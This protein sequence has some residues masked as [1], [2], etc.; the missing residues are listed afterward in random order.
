MDD[1]S[2]FFPCCISL[3]DPDSSTDLDYVL[4]TGL[5]SG[6]A[7]PDKFVVEFGSEKPT[8]LIK[9]GQRISVDQT[10][11]YMRGIPVN[12]KISGIITE[13]TD[14][15]FI[16]IYDKATDNLMSDLGLKDFSDK[17]LQTL[18]TDKKE[19]KFDQLNDLLKESSF[20][21]N[22]IKDYILRFRCADIANNYIQHTSVGV[23][24]AYNNTSRICEI[25]N[26]AADNIIDRYND[27]MRDI[28]QASSIQSYCENENLMGLKR[29][30]DSTKKKYFDQILWQYN[31]V[32]SFG[33]NSGRISDMMLYDEYMDYITSDDFVYDDENPYVVEL[34][35][36]ITTF[37]QVRSR[38]ELNSSNIAGLISKFNTLCNDNIRKYW[39]D[40]MYDYYGR[41]KQ[42]FFYDFYADNDKDLIEASIY[43]KKRVTLYS[44]VLKYLETL[45][46][47][48]PPMSAEEKYKDMDVNSII[49]NAQIQ[50]TASEKAMKQL[51]NNL[52]K[53]AIF[54]VQLKKIES[55]IDPKYFEQFAST[56]D[57]ND[58]FTLKEQLG[59]QNI[60]EY[61]LSYNNICVSGGDPKVIASA[62]SAYNAFESKY[63]DPFKKMVQSEAK[64]LR[65]LADKAISFYLDKD[66]KI[67]SGEIF[68]QFQEADWSGKSTVF[69]DNEP[70]DFFYISE[71]TT[72]T[73][74]M[75]APY[76]NGT[77]PSN[78]DEN[79]YQFGEDTLRTQFG[80]TDFEYWVKYC[81]IATIVNCML[82]MYWPTG[83]VIAG[84]PIPLPIIYI[85]FVVIKGRVTVV[86]GLGICGICPLPMLLFVNFGDIPGSLIPALNIAVDTI[87]AMVSMI[88]SISVK[89]IKETIKQM[90][91]AQ[92]KKINDLKEKKSEIKMNI[93]NLQAGVQTD[94]ET[95]RNLKK[96]RKDNPTTNTKKKQSSE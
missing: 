6:I 94:K 25:Y 22:F 45:C 63:L 15:Y 52:K 9:P 13:V 81:G 80:I 24:L 18:F 87:K 4:G 3:C 1:T 89:P 12:S 60:K 38:L 33:Y 72:T 93:Q 83:L 31:N 58:I 53:I 71:P 29:L 54:F 68:D 51:Y 40:K 86:I 7:G 57:Y 84:V 37:L 73:E 20:T 56:D 79:G 75:N 74:K 59:S 61:I 62:Q 82:P 43:D 41:I 36:H 76:M 27:E 65:K 85:P 10:I 5:F 70:H 69:K 17:S 2:T 50:D 32:P 48:T 35:Y 14:R 23:S 44:K 34:F 26:E 67:N 95:L 78:T 55:E 66:P 28:C 8:I 42:I 77:P 30:L 39:D 64:I 91:E 46:N 90:I 16:G 19:S 11:G 47:Y 96:K 49:N 92:D 88:P 21:N